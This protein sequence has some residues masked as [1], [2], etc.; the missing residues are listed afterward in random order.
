M[1]IYNVEVSYTES[2]TIR[3]KADS[4]QEAEEKTLQELDYDGLEAHPDRSANDREWY[5][6][7][8]DTTDGR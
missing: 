8:E 1:S 7:V 2:Y 6:Y 4:K 5:V 3:V